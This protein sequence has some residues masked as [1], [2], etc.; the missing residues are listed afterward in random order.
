MRKI[1]L[2]ICL[3]VFS[4]LAVAQ[5]GDYKKLVTLGNELAFNFNFDSCEVII[6]DAIQLNNDNPDAFLLKSK[7]HL[8]YFLGSKDQEDYKLFF[9]YSDSAVTRIDILLEENEDDL[10]LLYLLGNVYKYRAMAYGNNG[11]T[12]DAFWSTK[13]AVS[14][15]EDI[16]DVDSNYYAAYGGIGVFE[17]ALSY[18]PALFNWAISLSGLSA[19]QNNGFEFIELAADKA[20]LDKYEYQFHLS[21]LY[22][23]HLANYEKSISFL[24][25][26]IK[27]FPNNGLFHYQAAIEFIKSRD[28]KKAVV[29]LEHVLEINHLKFIQTN[30]FSNFLLGDIYFRENNYVK[31][32]EY[33]LTFLTTSQTIDY[34]GIAS[35]RAAYCFY[36][37]GNENDFRKYLLLAANG[38]LDLEDDNYANKMGLNILKDGFTK[39]KKVLLEADN[40]YLAGNNSK[41]LEIIEN[42]LDS[43]VTEEIVAEVG[44]LR[45]KILIENKSIELA[46]PIL[47]KIDSLD[48]DNAEWIE[49]L[50]YYYNA[51]ISYL[52]QNI[53]QANV[54]LEDAEDS[55]D[56]Q[57][58]NYIQ[59]L[60]NGLKLKL[61]ESN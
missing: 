18:V 12:L 13:K 34:T 37:L 20:D 5:N 14:Y 55:N 27:K 17:Y 54:Y 22:D 9:D 43:L 56:Y 39:E 15:Y 45:A 52:E 57:K 21:K 53:E 46:K 50:L 11:N 1:I 25:T 44:L 35:L 33:Y 51:E 40:S 10:D 24:N 8:W 28:L 61:G 32:L 38:N 7:I 26:L 58:K 47:E 16:I 3:L 4:Q 19:D 60:I 36:Y 29:E 2:V 59:S 49:P 30:S 42:N 23:E 48:I 6:N 31:A 41:S